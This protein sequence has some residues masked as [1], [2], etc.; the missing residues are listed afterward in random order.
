M[1]W[2]GPVAADALIA[3]IAVASI[4][5]SA[6]QDSLVRWFLFAFISIC[7]LSPGDVP[8]L[9]SLPGAPGGMRLAGNN[10]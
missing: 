2:G 7:L 4:A 3:T 9:L 10:A 6:G 8:A 5:I 1:F